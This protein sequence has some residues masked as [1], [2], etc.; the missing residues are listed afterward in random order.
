MAHRPRF[1]RFLAQTRCA[2]LLHVRRRLY[3]PF[4]PAPPAPDP[5][6]WRSRSWLHVLVVDDATATFDIGGLSAEQIQKASCAAIGFVFGK[7]LTVDELMPAI[8]A[9]RHA[10][11]D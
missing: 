5:T 4:V 9:T 10:T 1:C 2:L 3:P 7:V 8:S 11:A 6:G